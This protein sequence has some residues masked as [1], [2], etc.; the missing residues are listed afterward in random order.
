MEAYIRA[1]QLGGDE[2]QIALVSRSSD[3]ENLGREIRQSLSSEGQIKVFGRSHL[4][5]LANEL[6]GWITDSVKI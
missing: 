1:R 6:Q 4:D 3:P 2:A 5:N